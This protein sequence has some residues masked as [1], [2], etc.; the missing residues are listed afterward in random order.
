MDR[1]TL[2]LE[3]KRLIVDECDRDIEPSALPDDAP[4]F[5]PE[6]ALD[7]DSLDGLQISMA[8]QKRYGIRIADPKQLRRILT[9]IDALAAYLEAQ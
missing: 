8:L 3:L 4:L 7:L 6:S 1:D 2:K 9:S 5:G